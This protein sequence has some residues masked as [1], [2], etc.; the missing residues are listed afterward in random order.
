MILIETIRA[1]RTA[2]RN[3]RTVGQSVGFVPTMGFLH[4]GHLSLVRASKARADRTVVS[5]FVN[6][7]Q[8]GPDEDLERYPRDLARDRALLER[9]GVDVLFHPS[10]EEMYPEGFR[11]SVEVRGLQ[12]PLCGRSRPGHFAGVAT[13]CLKLF[14]I[15]RPD[16]A[17]FGQKDAQQAVLV[18][19]MAQDLNLDL[20]VVVRPTV[21]E[22]DGLAMSSRNGYLSPEERAAAPV[23]YR[24]LERA[25]A[26][27]EA[28]ERDAGRI[29]EAVRG[30]IGGE[31]LAAVE[32]VDV[33]DPAELL[34][35]ERIEGAALVALAVRF[36]ST[37]LIDN[38]LIQAKET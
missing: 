17:Y 30:A 26:L 24:S 16:E 9:E 38:I 6:P 25:R 11:T 19:R 18:R 20:E 7:A 1:M 13:V 34:P 35:L 5:I 2:V 28:G 31:P 23:L 12:D 8:F 27:Y 32:Y 22:T 33:V 14:E 3:F 29:A 4:E 36:G 37:R 15:V 21:R 10:R